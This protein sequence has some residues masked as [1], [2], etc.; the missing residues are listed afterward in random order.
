MLRLPQ[1]DL[2][3]QSLGKYRQLSQNNQKTEHTA[4]KT[5]LT[6]MEPAWGL[7]SRRL[8]MIM[9]MMI[10]GNKKHKTEDNKQTASAMS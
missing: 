10:N 5:I 3:I 1:R 2:S 7:Y 8:L 9:M 4:T 6:A